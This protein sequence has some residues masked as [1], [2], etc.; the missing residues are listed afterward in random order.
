MDVIIDRLHGYH[1]RGSNYNELQ[2]Y[3]VSNIR[4]G[5]EFKLAQEEVEVILDCTDRKK[6]LFAVK[7]QHARK[8]LETFQYPNFVYYRPLQ[9]TFIDVDCGAHDQF[10]TLF[11]WLGRLAN[12]KANSNTENLFKNIDREPFSL[13]TAAERF[14]LDGY[15]FFSS[16]VYKGL[17]VPRFKGYPIIY[18]PNHKL[19]F[20]EKMIFDG[21]GY[22]PLQDKDDM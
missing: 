6:F 8:A 4:G 18:S 21:Y 2:E 22:D 3:L 12:S 9:L 15:G 10:M 14:I 20:A 13:S 7:I 17:G 11:Y 5:D 16:S 19:S 1:S